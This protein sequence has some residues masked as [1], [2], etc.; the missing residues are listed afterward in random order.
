MYRKDPEWIISQVLW[1]QIYTSV[2]ESRFGVLVVDD[3]A[4][5]LSEVIRFETAEGREF[6]TSDKSLWWTLSLLRMLARDVDDKSEPRSEALVVLQPTIIFLAGESSNQFRFSDMCPGAQHSSC[7]TS[8][9]FSPPHGT[10]RWGCRWRVGGRKHLL[11][12]PSPLSCLSLQTAEVNQTDR[13]KW[14]RGPGAVLASQG[15]A[16]STH[17][18][19]LS[20]HLFLMETF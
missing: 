1:W 13:E 19:A 18:Q 17:V 11:W 16:Y 15:M 5:E 14:T 4:M 9:I 6:K 12:S 10:G 2:G 3:K 8:Q 20:P 7:P